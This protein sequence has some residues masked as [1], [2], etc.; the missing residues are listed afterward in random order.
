VVS[1]ALQLPE[2]EAKDIPNGRLTDKFPSTTT[3]WLILRKF[4]S[5][6]SGGGAHARNFT[7]RGI[8]QT[9]DDVSGAGRLYYETPVVQAMG[10]EL[11]SFTDLQKTLGQLGFN[12]GSILL[13]LSFRATQKPLEEAM[14][15]IEQYFKAIDSE[16]TSAGAHAGSVG[17]FRSRPETEETAPQADN[18]GLKTPPGEP[19]EASSSTDPAT[20]TTAPITDPPNGEKRKAASPATSPSPPSPVQQQ[21]QPQQQ[22]PPSPSLAPTRPL[23]IYLP[24]TTTTPTAALHPHNPTDYIPTLDHARQH[25]SHL[26]TTA[27]NRRLPS[28][29]EL[30]AAAAAQA[31]TLAAVSTVEI[32][33]RFPD[34]TTVVAAFGPTDTAA[35]L[36]AFVRGLLE[37]EEAGFVLSFVGKGGRAVVVPVAGE[38]RL[39]GGLGMRGRVLVVFRWEGDGG[40]WEGSVLKREFGERARE[41][42]VEN[43]GAAGGGRGEGREGE[44]A[45][46]GGGAGAVAGG[47]KETAGG[48]GGARKGGVPKWLKLPGKK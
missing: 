18:S 6:A 9:N 28:D 46:V 47:E 3:L 11:W 20:T 7:A 32:K 40:G 34:Q 15:E 36:Y 29:S 39:V 19:T 41:L 43:V 26:S 10:R 45:G 2:S 4:E 31:T 22:N 23:T 13:R 38:E 5:D 12:S 8:A 25:Q 21:Q 14:T 33:I 24:P 16:G 35:G 44:G 27:R 1:V 42:V 30:A 17:A 48:K 37:K